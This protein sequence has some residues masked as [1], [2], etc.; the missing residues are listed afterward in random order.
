M[1]SCRRATVVASVVLLLAGGASASAAVIPIDETRHLTASLKAQTRMTYEEGRVVDGAQTDGRFDGSVHRMYVILGGQMN[2]RL[3][4][5]AIFAGNRVGQAGRDA[6]AIGVGTAF[7]VR[8]A[9]VR[10]D[11]S[12]ALRVQVG[13]MYVP[14]LRCF[15]TEGSFAI[16]TL[17]LPSHQAGG[18]IPGLRAARDDGAV[19]WGNLSGGT[20]QYRVG[21]MDGSDA[22]S[23]GAP[24]LAGRLVLN[25]LRPEPGWF[26]T[27]AHLSG[28]GIVSV[29]AGVDYLAGFNADGAD[30][31]GVTGDVYCSV[32]VTPD[33]RAIAE[34]SLTA[35]DQDDTAWSGTH[36]SGTLGIVV[37]TSA[38]PA[39]PVHPYVAYQKLRPANAVVD[40]PTKDTEFS[41]GVNFYPG[42]LEHAFKITLDWTRVTPRDEPSYGRATAQTQLSF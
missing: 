23:G 29:G 3:S 25:L 20:A 21:V 18:L 38:S 19:A 28:D 16:Q 39:G 13:R 36:Y 35:V 26:T 32:P 10:M 17:D 11:V 33:L 37:A 24:R 5:L 15:G 31:L 41:V 7:A 2:P 8:D 9:W 27:A 14:F 6:S 42:R 4:M 22:S 40:P 12:D 30:H 1:H 34:G